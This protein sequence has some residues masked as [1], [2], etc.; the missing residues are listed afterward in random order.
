MYTVYN[1]RER[2]KR[3]R[4][5]EGAGQKLSLHLDYCVSLGRSNIQGLK[6]ATMRGG[7]SHRYTVSFQTQA[8]VPFTLLNA[9]LQVF[10]SYKYVW[11]LK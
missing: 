1:V 4:E 3:E 5:R 8:N 9:H 11:S 2:E 6:Q 10:I 7:F